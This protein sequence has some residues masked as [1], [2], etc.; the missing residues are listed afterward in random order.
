MESNYADCQAQS[1]LRDSSL[2]TF[3]NA[4]KWGFVIK[5]AMQ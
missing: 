4:I 2:Q 3:Y 5:A 1:L